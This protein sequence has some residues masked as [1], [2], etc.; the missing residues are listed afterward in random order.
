MSGLLRTS[1]NQAHTAS[2][3]VGV[4][5]TILFDAV[6]GNLGNL[7]RFCVREDIEIASG[8]SV[9]ATP[10]G[11]FGLAPR[12]TAGPA[13]PAASP[14]CSRTHRCRA[15]C[16]YAF[17]AESGPPRSPPRPRSASTPRGMS[18]WL[19]EKTQRRGS[20]T[21]S[22]VWTRPRSWDT[23]RLRVAAVPRDQWTIEDQRTPSHE[24][25]GL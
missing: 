3:A 24:L 18:H 5:R 1:C 14:T 22:A 2:P 8:P 4:N 25:S 6:K 13:G 11:S 9:A 7:R 12:A 23:I 19:C 15:T 17:A 10:R 16:P 20:G 21:T